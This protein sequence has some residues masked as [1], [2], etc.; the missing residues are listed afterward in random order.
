MPPTLTERFGEAARWA[1]ELHNDDTRKGTDVPYVSHLF[2]VASLVLEDGGDED[3]AIAA[4]LHDSVEDGHTT[5]GE[6]RERFGEKVAD[7][8]RACSDTNGADDEI[9][10]S[11]KPWRARKEGYVAHLND[12]HA[13]PS[14]L[15]VSNADKVHN[16]RCILAD[17]RAKGD[18]LWLR[19]NPD[20]QSAEMQLWYYGQLADAFEQRRGNTPLANELRSIVDQL[21]TDTGV[22]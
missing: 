1:A 10:E 18:A 9:V 19:F 14:A 8:V 12:P 11:K 16:A 22:S 5:F 13:S 15:R 17:Y 21:R 6:V 4:L 7:I 3:E 2:A 20:A